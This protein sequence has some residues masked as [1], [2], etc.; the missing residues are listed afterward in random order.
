MKKFYESP[1]AVEVKIEAEQM[2]ATSFPLNDDTN[3]RVNTE[4]D[5]VQLS[6]GH[7]GQWGNLWQ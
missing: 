4:D 3:D 5:G 7:R 2:L 6:A 1:L